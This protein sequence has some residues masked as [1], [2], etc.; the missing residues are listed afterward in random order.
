MN[1]R[2]LS[3]LET[4]DCVFIRPI[5]IVIYFGFPLSSSWQLR[6]LH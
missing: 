6:N 5:T 1:M 4:I 2:S 3:S